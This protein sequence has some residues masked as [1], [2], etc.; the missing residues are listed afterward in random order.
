[1]I[2]VVE[3]YAFEKFSGVLF[4]GQYLGYGVQYF[5]FDLFEAR[6]DFCGLILGVKFL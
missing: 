5:G 2:G 4:S 1:M 6:F 3:V